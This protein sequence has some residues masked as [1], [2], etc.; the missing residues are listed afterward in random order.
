MVFSRLSVG[1][2]SRPGSWT[3][4][5]ASFCR[6]LQNGSGA[7]I[8]VMGA[9]NQ[10]TS[11]KCSVEILAGGPWWRHPPSSAVETHLQVRLRLLCGESTLLPGHGMG[12]FRP[13]HFPQRRTSSVPVLTRVCINRVGA[14]LVVSAVLPVAFVPPLWVCITR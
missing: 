7:C 12:L 4:A 8:S 14:V 2:L 1:C 13:C 5:T 11:Q 10:M 9:T 6:P 3:R